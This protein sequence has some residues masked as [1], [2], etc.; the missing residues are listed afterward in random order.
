MDEAV[1]QAKQE[2]RNVWSKVVKR[3]K[4]IRSSRNMNIDFKRPRKIAKSLSRHL[5]IDVAQKAVEIREKQDEFPNEVRIAI[6]QLAKEPKPQVF[7]DS[8][9]DSLLNMIEESILSRKEPD[10]TDAELEVAI[11][12]FPNALWY[13]L[14]HTYISEGSKHS[15][16][17]QLH[18][19]INFVPFVPVFV[20]LGIE[21]GWYSENERGG[22]MKYR[23]GYDGDDS[24]MGHNRQRLNL[25]EY[26]CLWYPDLEPHI[27]PEYRRQEGARIDRICARAMEGLSKYGAFGRQNIIEYNLHVCA[28]RMRWRGMHVNRLVYMN[29][30]FPDLNF[31]P[32]P[33]RKEL[34]EAGSLLSDDNE[35]GA[36]MELEDL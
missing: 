4:D 11:R 13:P 9:E 12:S 7:V 20:K 5:K 28:V 6:R 21:S 22:L 2:Q 26:I 1:Q 14:E 31:A 29:Q 27:H 34:K 18:K 23:L 3:G 25:L 36:Y 32:E 17:F 16:L 24:A 35:E 30:F 8:I 10:C 15:E 19:L 33:N